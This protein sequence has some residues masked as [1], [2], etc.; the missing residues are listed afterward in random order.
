MKVY[1]PAV[2]TCVAVANLAQVSPADAQRCNGC[3]RGPIQWNQITVSPPAARMPMAYGRPM[4][5]ST[6]MVTQRSSYSGLHQA[7]RPVATRVIRYGAGTAAGTYL[8][9]QGYP[10]V[11]RVVRFTRG[12]PTGA[13]LWPTCVGE[14][15]TGWKRVVFP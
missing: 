4:P 9:N 2:I 15:C 5:A 11:G 1:L 7:A 13:L 14:G 12:G 8:I 6:P 10:V 3:V